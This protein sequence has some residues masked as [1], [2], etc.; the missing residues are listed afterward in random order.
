MSSLAFVFFFSVKTGLGLRLCLPVD[1]TLLLVAADSSVPE[2]EHGRTN[3]F[4]RMTQCGNGHGW[5]E[6]GVGLEL[7]EVTPRE[8]PT[9]LEGC[10]EHPVPSTY[11]D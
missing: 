10:H 1:T 5:Q 8:E 11:R 3:D 6:V 2:T 4:L 7:D 9:A